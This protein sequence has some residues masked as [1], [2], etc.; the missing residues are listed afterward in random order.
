MA[1]YLHVAG[2]QEHPGCCVD[3]LTSELYPAASHAAAPQS[4]SSVVISCAGQLAVMCAAETSLVDSEQM[5]SVAASLREPGNPATGWTQS[6]S[7]GPEIR[8]S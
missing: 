6:V 2:I 3:L 5:Q 8:V 7:A 4:L 1:A